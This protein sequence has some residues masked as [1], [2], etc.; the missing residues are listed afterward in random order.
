MRRHKA[1]GVK[2]KT[3]YQPKWK[4][5]ETKTIRVPIALEKDILKIAKALD[6]E[7]INADDILE[8]FLSGKRLDTRQIN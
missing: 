6:N 8:L 4:H 2:T 1:M 5:G 3:S 7:Y